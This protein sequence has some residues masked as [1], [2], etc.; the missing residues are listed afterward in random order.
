LILNTVVP[1]GYDTLTDLLGMASKQQWDGW[2]EKQAEVEAYLAGDDG[3]GSTMT[4]WLAT[5][6]AE[7]FRGNAKQCDHAIAELMALMPLD[8]LVLA[9]AA[10]VLVNFG[11][12]R[13]AAQLARQLVFYGVDSPAGRIAAIVLIQ[14]LHLEE[15]FE[16][17]A[18]RDDDEAL[19]F[20][21][22][23][24]LDVFEKEG[25]SLE[26]RLALYE[27]VVDIARQRNAHIVGCKAYLAPDFGFAHYSLMVKSTTPVDQDLYDECVG[28]VVDKFA[29]AFG[30]CLMVCVEEQDIVVVH[31]IE[32][33]V[34]CL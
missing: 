18:E 10:T 21:V 22:G 11:Y 15:A 13:E 6:W 12:V 26:W 5:A 34:V 7:Y 30:E 2:A 9:N 17:L 4:R 33:A 32:E 1:F 23:Y 16:V 28:A 24:M 31:N 3:S 20:K 8:P 14:S 29:N 27:T 19:Y 25:I